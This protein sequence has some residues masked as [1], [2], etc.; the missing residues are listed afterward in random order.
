M[1]QRNLIIQWESPRAQVRQVVKDQGVAHVDPDAYERMYGP[2]LV[3]G[4]KALR[5]FGRH[6]NT[7]IPFADQQKYVQDEFEY[8]LEGELEGLQY[9]DLDEFGLGGYSAQLLAKGIR[10]LGAI[11]AKYNII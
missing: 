1:P 6:L 11:K 2:S 5:R 7:S 4:S 9:I 8:E 3:R 10:D